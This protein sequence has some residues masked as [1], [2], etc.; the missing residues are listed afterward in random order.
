ME[1]RNAAED[2][3]AAADVVLNFNKKASMPAPSGGVA[4]ALSLHYLLLHL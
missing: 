4:G 1:D 2:E 3:S